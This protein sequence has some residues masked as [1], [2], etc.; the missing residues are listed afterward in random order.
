MRICGSAPEIILTDPHSLGNLQDAL[1]AVDITG[2][3][4]YIYI[5]QELVAVNSEMQELNRQIVE[6]L[7]ELDGVDDVFHSMDNA[8]LK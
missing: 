7:K 1:H 2:P 4:R 8:V 5:P 6:E 3:S